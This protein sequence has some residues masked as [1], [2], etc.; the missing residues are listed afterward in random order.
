MEMRSSN[1]VLN[2]NFWSNLSGNERMTLE[3]SMQKIG[4]LLGLTV[5]SALVSAVLCLNALNTGNG[6]LTIG[7]LTMLGF[8]G[9]FI[10]GL[11]VVFVRPQNPAPLMSLYAMFQ[12]VAVG[13]FSIYFESSYPG[14]VF[15][16]AF[17]TIGITGTMYVMYASRTIRPTPTFNKVIG[18]LVFSIMI[19]YLMSFTLS[20]FTAYSVPFLHS[21][22]PIGIAVTAFIL[23]VASLT[24]ISDFGFIES[25]TRYGAPKNMEWYAAFGILMS[26]I[27]IYI[28]M[29]KLIW[30][31]RA[32]VQD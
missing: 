9:G 1:P 18:G 11:V 10:L 32:F 17:G 23:V 4:Y 29:V 2:Q 25:G 31:L 16:A 20:L 22:G 24:L 30:K 15:Q 8:G 5:V 27:W 12:G 28:E 6:G 13:A 19:L 7:G 21:T 3:G 26:L 14:I